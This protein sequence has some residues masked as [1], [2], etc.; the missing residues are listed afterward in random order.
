MLNTKSSLKLRQMSQSCLRISGV[1]Q[2][3]CAS[4][5]FI[6]LVTLRMDRF[7]LN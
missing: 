6:P 4:G 2:E 1:L 3:V 5:A 7:K